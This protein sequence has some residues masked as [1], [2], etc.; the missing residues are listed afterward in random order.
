M[1]QNNLIFFNFSNYLIKLFP[2]IL[3]ID[4][5]FKNEIIITIPS[6][7]IKEFIYFLKNHT[8][9]QYKLLSDIC[10]VDFL[11]NINRFEIVYNILSIR[12]NTKLRIKTIVNELTPIN[13]ITSIFS[14]ANWWERE[15]WDL[16]GIFFSKHPDLRRILTDYG[17]DGHPFRKDFPLSGFVELRYDENQKCI[18]C[19]PLML[20][21][22]YRFYNFDNALKIL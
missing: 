17:F 6:V 5:F 7:L 8:N 11:K 14:C 21:Q 3:S 12:Y 9:C 19:E 10:A 18:I 16:F 20:P 15:I 4:S 2:G 13:T 22:K 1:I